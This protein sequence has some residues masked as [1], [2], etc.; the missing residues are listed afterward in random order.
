M[1][2]P[3]KNILARVYKECGKE[4]KTCVIVCECCK[5]CK[6]NTIDLFSGL[7]VRI[8]A[9]CA[10]MLLFTSFAPSQLPA[11]VEAYH[12]AFS[13]T[14]EPN[15]AIIL[16]FFSELFSVQMQCSSI[17]CYCTK[18]TLL[19]AKCTN[20]EVSNASI[21]FMPSTKCMLND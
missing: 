7:M 14:L 17:F 19:L 3:S 8:V 9:S 20:T 12:Y 11:S 13:S 2:G 5:R 1:L 10:V 21:Q 6:R 16:S 4:F 15:V 18:L